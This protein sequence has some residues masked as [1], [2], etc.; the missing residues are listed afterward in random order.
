MSRGRCPT[1][2]RFLAEVTA[3]VRE[4]GGGEAL[5]QITGR[6]RVHGEVDAEGDFAWEDFFG[7][8]A[9]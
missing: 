5:D 2:G 1:C 8:D 4:V 3:T 6:C 7:A 9:E